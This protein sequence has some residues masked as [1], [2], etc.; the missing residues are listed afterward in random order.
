MH[1]EPAK[2]IIDVLGGVPAVAEIT[3]A[4]VTRVRRWRLPLSSGGTDGAI[5]REHVFPLY[6]EFVQRGLAAQVEDIVFTPEQRQALRELSQ[7]EPPASLRKSQEN[8]Q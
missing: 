2:T 6:R 3:G 5:P 4:H 7:T 8:T 1:M